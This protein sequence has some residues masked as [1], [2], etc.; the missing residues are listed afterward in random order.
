M[1][2]DDD[3]RK[4]FTKNSEVLLHDG[5]RPQNSDDLVYYF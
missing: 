3:R 1:V 5:L 2:G 4:Y